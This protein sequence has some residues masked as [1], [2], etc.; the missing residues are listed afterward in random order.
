MMGNLRMINFREKE[1]FIKRMGQKTMENGKMEGN[2]EEDN[3][4]YKMK[5]FIKVYLDKVKEQMEFVS[6][7]KILYIMM[8]S[9]KIKNFKEEEFYKM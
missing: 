9:L 3:K 2:K 4:S 6:M 8:E 1:Y 7:R 5:I